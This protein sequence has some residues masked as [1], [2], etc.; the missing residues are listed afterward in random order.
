[1]CMRSLIV[2]GIAS[3]MFAMSSKTTIDPTWESK[4]CAAAEQASG[5][6]TCAFSD[7]CKTC[8]ISC[9]PGKTESVGPLFTTEPSGGPAVCWWKGDDV[10][11][12]RTCTCASA[13]LPCLNDC[14]CSESSS[15]GAWRTFNDVWIVSTTPCSETGG[16]P[17]TPP[18]N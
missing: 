10:P 1:M 17:D 12:D 3:G 15:C 7:T 4:K 16:C 9:K 11:C 6:P 2:V 5:T 18:E 14:Y 8:S 13:Y